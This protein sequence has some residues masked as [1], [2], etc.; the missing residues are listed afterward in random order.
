[1]TAKSLSAEE[2]KNMIKQANQELV[3]S[4]ETL[5]QEMDDFKTYGQSQATIGLQDTQRLC[6]RA[7]HGTYAAL[8]YDYTLVLSALPHLSLAGGESF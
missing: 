5:G 7:S 3:V 8:C 1:M 6:M 4:V 2:Q